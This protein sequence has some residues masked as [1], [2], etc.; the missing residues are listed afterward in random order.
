[1]Y[2]LPYIFL[3]S[4]YNSCFDNNVHFNSKSIIG[5]LF[6]YYEF[7]FIFF[8]KS[9]ICLTASS[10][11]NTTLICENDIDFFSIKSCIEPDMI[12]LYFVMKFYNC[13][14]I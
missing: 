4:Q 10:I 2:L 3:I 9:Q 1:M 8:Q 6:L 14:K 11:L 7:R 5:N 12:V 13:Y